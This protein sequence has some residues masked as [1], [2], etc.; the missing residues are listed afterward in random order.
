MKVDGVN[1]WLVLPVPW[2]SVSSGGKMPYLRSDECFD[3]FDDPAA[4]D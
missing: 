2:Y 1:A 3:V 4:C